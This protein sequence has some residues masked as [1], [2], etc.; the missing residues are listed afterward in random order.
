MFLVALGRDEK[1]RIEPLKIAVD[2]QLADVALNAIDG[3]TMA[4]GCQLESLKPVPLFHLAQAIIV[5]K[6]EMRCRARGL[7]TGP[8]TTVEQHDFL[9][10]SRDKIGRAHAGH[11]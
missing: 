8:R 11:S 7:S 10:L 3:I 6:T 4:L 2:A 5:V 1:I 9:S